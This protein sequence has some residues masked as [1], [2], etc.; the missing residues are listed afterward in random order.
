MLIA[1]KA[2]AGSGKTYTLVREYL[3]LAMME[4]GG[5]RKILAITFTNKAAQEMKERIIHVLSDMSDTAKTGGMKEELSRMLGLPEA[6][7]AV[8]AGNLLRD[9]LHHYSDFSVGTIDSFV[10][11]VVKG[12]AYEL[13]LPPGYEIELDT[14]AVMLQSA[15]LLIEAAG[16]EESLLGKTLL[17]FSMHEL[18]ESGKLQINHKIARLGKQL[19][20]EGAILNR[21]AFRQMSP[22]QIYAAREYCG[23][24]LAEMKGI[25]KKEARAAMKIIRSAG[26]GQE[27]FYQTN[28]GIYNFFHHFAS[29]G[30][31]FDKFKNTYVARSIYQ[32]QWTASKAGNDIK[33]KIEGIKDELRSHFLVMNELFQERGSRFLLY[34]LLYK[35]FYSFSLL[36]E[37]RQVLETLK[38]EEGLMLLAEFHEMVYHYVSRQ[39]AP[40]IYERLG[41]R[42][43]HLLIDEF[44]DTSVVQWRNLLPLVEHALYNSG[45]CLLVGDPKQAIYRFRGGRV[46]QFVELPHIQGSEEDPILS[47]RQ[48]AINNHGFRPERLGTNYRSEAHI[49]HFNNDFYHWLAGSGRLSDPRIYEGHEQLNHHKGEQGYVNI[50]FLKSGN[51]EETDVSEQ[52][53]SETLRLIKTNLETGYRFRDIAILTNSNETG[54]KMASRLM[55]SGIPVV[56]GESLLIRLDP[57]VQ[58]LVSA[59]R[60]LERPSERLLRAVFGSLLSRFLQRGV[61][62]METV[63]WKMPETEFLAWLE[64]LSGKA[65][66]LLFFRNRR[67]QDV[68][69]GLLEWLGLDAATDPYLHAFRDAVLQFSRR[70]GGS[71]S[72]FLE[73]WEDHQQKCSILYPEDLD[74]VRIMTIHKSKG[75][76]FPVV[77]LC[78]AVWNAKASSPFLWLKGLEQD[79]PGLP[80][81]LVS[82]NSALENTRYADIKLFEK[83]MD[84][85]EAVNKLYVATT[86]AEQR[87]Y[88]LSETVKKSDA[89]SVRIQDLLKSYLASKSLWQ[90]DLLEYEF[91]N[92]GTFKENKRPA[93]PEN[94]MFR[95]RQAGRSARM[96][97][98]RKRFNGNMKT[99]R[100][101]SFHTMASFWQDEET[102]GRRIS[103]HAAADD[104]AAV[105]LELI[106]SHE[107]LRKCFEPGQQVFN[108][109]E[110]IIPGG[111]SFRPDR[112]SIDPQSG[113]ARLLDF[114]T[115]TARAEHSEQM[116]RYLQAL[117]SLGF[118]IEICLL[119]YIDSRE[120]VSVSLNPSQ[121]V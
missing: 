62:A 114:K 26:L 115:G 48:H 87:L 94:Y 14:D 76:Q 19:F 33:E 8:K 95:H 73:F 2:S 41:E 56:S 22:E 107:A 118:K 101:E 113:Q 57:N 20:E 106:K 3:R 1:C 105:L 42:Y 71:L 74:A 44:Q 23:Q 68:L 15:D 89:E 108:E 11:R 27:V 47:M 13:R 18:E 32:D 61:P 21:D 38:A 40:V 100:G 30:I 6:V 34:Q 119:V 112:L 85:L 16:N 97:G 111:R 25:L 88:I 99:R 66:P 43:H 39:E 70:H 52:R 92:P 46:E 28:K 79:I 110:F 91:G 83:G 103:E 35:N 90:E 49:V 45:T 64:N 7:V 53:L 12:F 116:I 109:R 93:P 78:D 65:F 5:Y 58:L 102:L 72:Q 31:E 60:F 82:N 96:P 54:A 63:E 36:G 51:E 104:Q 59:L 84:Q 120:V 29:G 17:E 55:E 86:R 121:Q 24:Q 77:I 9:I 37:F 67:L 10:H 81:A 80:L 50:R 69:E 75:L 4:D 98:I 117:T